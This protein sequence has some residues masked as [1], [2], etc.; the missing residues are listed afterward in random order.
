MQ[1]NSPLSSVKATPEHARQAWNV[2]SSAKQ[3]MHKAGRKQWQGDYPSA[4][5]VD[6]DIAAGVGRVLVVN[7]RVV[8]YCAFITTGEP[9]YAKITD[10][11][12]LTPDGAQYA[13]VHRLAIYSKMTGC[14]LASRWM[15]LLLDEA[16]TLQCQSMRIDTNYDNEQMLRLLPHSGFTYCGIVQLPGGERRAFEHLL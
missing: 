8:G 16:S 3:A 7:G 11:H 4:A 1:L 10:G 5:D 2:L 14:G 12:W 13:V 6:R 15:H 9:A